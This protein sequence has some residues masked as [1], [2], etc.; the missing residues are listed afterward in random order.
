MIKIRD[1]INWLL[2]KNNKKFF[3][4]FCKGVINQKKNVTKKCYEKS[5]KRKVLRKKCYDLR[6]CFTP[7]KGY[8]NKWLKKGK[9]LTD[10]FQKIIKNYLLLFFVTFLRNIFFFLN[11]PLS[12]YNKK[13]FIIF[14]KG[15]I[16]QKKNV[17][18][19]C[20]EYSVTKKVLHEKC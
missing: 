20:Y 11:D 6:K 5:V 15:V 14:C 19:K 9:L 2:S 17:T 8:L 7:E 3:I 1:D 10:S 18:K 12:K 16:H 13:F 4:T